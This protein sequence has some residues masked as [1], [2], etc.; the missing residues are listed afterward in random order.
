[1]DS[2]TDTA[3]SALLSRID[4]LKGRPAIVAIDGGA[5]GGKTTLAAGLA[6]RFGAD[7]LHM[8]DF[9]LQPH[10][11]TAQRLGEPGGNVDY[12]R[13]A[14]EVLLPLRRGERYVYR[15]YDCRTQTLGA[16]EMRIP[17]PLTIVE[18]SY[19]LHP[20]L[21]SQYDL[22]V[23]L[24]VDAATQS[25]RILKRNGAD[26]HRRFM[27]EW[28]PLEN[29]YFEATDIRSRCDVRLSA[30]ALEEWREDA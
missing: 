24:E 7:V 22:R 19:S 29:R 15:R 8:D 20:A 27:Q 28:I 18:G 5:A 9:F 14:R 16:G 17:A 3:I 13:F 30:Q 23:L 1:M 4:A 12:E 11:R 10:Q 25:A 6:R 26:K 21:A 2:N